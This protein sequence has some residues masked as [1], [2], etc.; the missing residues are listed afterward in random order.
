MKKMKRILSL[1]LAIVT[2]LGLL[3]TTAFARV[4]KT[5][6]DEALD[7]VASKTFYILRSDE[8][9]ALRIYKKGGGLITGRTSTFGTTGT[10]AELKI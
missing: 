4:D 6:L 9:V 10:A 5:N 3:P 2:I 8:E 7:G 1:F